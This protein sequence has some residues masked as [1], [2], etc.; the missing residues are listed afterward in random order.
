MNLKRRSQLE[1]LQCYICHK[2]KQI[3]KPLCTF[4]SQW[5]LKSPTT[6]NTFG[7]PGLHL[8]QL[9]WRLPL[10]PS[11]LF[12]LKE[13]GHLESDRLK[14]CCIWW[15]Y[16]AITHIQSIIHNINFRG[17]KKKFQRKLCGDSGASTFDRFYLVDVTQC[18]CHDQCYFC[19]I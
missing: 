6:V 12:C 2:W 19:H 15:P 1:D 18:T 16:Y 7:S 8:Q 10:S 5:V 13:D 3:N 4:S 11:L 9:S 17:E 14:T